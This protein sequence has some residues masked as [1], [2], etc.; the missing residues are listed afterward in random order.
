[1]EMEV[2]SLIDKLFEA[3]SIT[4]SGN[5]IYIRDMK[6]DVSRWSKKAVEY[7]DLPGEYMKDAGA[8]WEERLHPDDRERYHQVIQEVFDGTR[9]SMELEYRVRDKEGNYVVCSAKGS[10]IRDDNEE[11]IYFAGTIF[12]HGIVDNIDPTTSLYNQYEFFHALRL[13]KERKASASILVLGIKRFSEIND[14]YGYT[15]GNAV[16]RELA[17]KMMLILKDES[18][19]YRLDGTR[20]GICTKSTDKAEI[21]KMYKTIWN[22]ARNEIN[23][24]GHAITVDICGGAVISE[25][26]VLDEH[27]IYAKG[28]YAL[29][30]SKN[31]KHG[32][33]VVVYDDGKINGSNRENIEI[34]NEIR[35][36]VV[37]GCEGFYLCYQPFV[38]SISE[39]LL[40]M[41]VLLRWKKEPYGNVPPDRFIPWLERDAVFFDLSNWILEEALKEGKKI[42][43]R[44]PDFVINVNLSYAQLE[45]SEFRS[46]ITE[47][48]ER[49]GFP[50][51][52]LCLELTE[53]CRLLD[54]SFLR[55]EII[56]LKS[57]GIKV[58]LD[59]FG[60]GFSSLNLLRELPIDGIKIDRGFISDITT[61]CKNQS[62]VKAVTQCAKELDLNV[63]VEGIEDEEMKDFMGNFNSSSYQGYYYSRPVV[64]DE[65]KKL[66]LF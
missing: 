53:R 42:L 3:F 60:T 64:M 32:E 7:F 22:M 58:V 55:N 51:K 4:S 14:I 21:E 12:N 10:V 44:Y 66:S 37:R 43:E 23:L 8:I 47:L 56:F 35:N 17:K 52:N 27:D 30:M 39:K 18:W 36:C 19:V 16:L 38:S 65:F 33:L 41:E 20:F 59:D 13:L 48:L 11:P 45:R 5:Y 54:L 46:T 49:S 31:E 57:Y 63:C 40:G 50:A 34:L 15:V 25:N 62:I 26:Y 28:R 61:N 24:N 6:T 29:D 9:S 1:M 2:A